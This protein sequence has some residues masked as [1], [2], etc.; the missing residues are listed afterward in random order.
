MGLD[1]EVFANFRPI[2]NLMFMSK[3]TERAIAPQLIDY[4]TMNNLDE[5]FQ[6]AH[7]QL[8]ST[9]TALLRVQNDIL[10]ALDS[11]DRTRPRAIPLAMITTRK[12]IHGFPLVSYMGMGLRYNHACPQNHVNSQNKQGALGQSV[13]ST[14]YNTTNFQFRLWKVIRTT[15]FSHV[16]A[17]FAGPG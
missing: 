8:H 17:T 1:F 2:S 12:S 14:M 10:V 3:L 4:I 5:V 13:V 9:E 15:R 11:H 16:L 7:K 6:S